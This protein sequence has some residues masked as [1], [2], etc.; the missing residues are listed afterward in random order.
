M[1]EITREGF[2]LKRQLI[3]EAKKGKQEKQV[4]DDETDDWEILSHIVFEFCLYA[5]ILFRRIN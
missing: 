1:A 2:L 4:T 5:L 3:E